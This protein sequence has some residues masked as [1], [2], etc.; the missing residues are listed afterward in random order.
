MEVRPQRQQRDDE[1]DLPGGPARLGAQQQQQCREEGQRE[2]LHPDDRQTRQGAEG[3]DQQRAADPDR[4]RSARTCVTGQQHQADR[5]GRQ[6]REQQSTGPE[7][8]I[9]SV[10]DELGENQRVRPVSGRRARERDPRSAPTRGARCRDRAR[11]ATE[12]RSRCGPGARASARMNTI[13]VARTARAPMRER[14]ICRDTLLDLI[15]RAVTTSPGPWCRSP[16]TIVGPAPQW[17]EHSLIPK[18]VRAHDL[19]SGFGS[20]SIP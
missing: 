19:V 3:D 5:D 7:R 8:S 11:P 16:P 13:V 2:Q 12:N 10:E 17:D 15:A 14:S 4:I 9:E 1:P 18:L 20:R 6:L